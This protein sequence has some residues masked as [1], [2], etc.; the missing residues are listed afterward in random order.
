LTEREELQL[1]LQTLTTA[2]EVYQKKEQEQTEQLNQL[3]KEYNKTLD[4]FQLSE[5][6]VSLLR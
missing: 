6:T 3:M 2:I 1:K 4:Q 5:E